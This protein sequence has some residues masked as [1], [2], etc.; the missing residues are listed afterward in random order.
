M[1]TMTSTPPVTEENTQ[2]GIVAKIKG[3]IRRARLAVAGGFATAAFAIAGAGSAQAAEG[4]DPTGGAGATFFSTI[5]DY[6]TGNLIAA[7]LGLAVI[8]VVVSLIIKWG[9]KAAKSS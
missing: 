5:T 3:G 8:G 2:G 1:D 6:L 4:D 9:K 7:V